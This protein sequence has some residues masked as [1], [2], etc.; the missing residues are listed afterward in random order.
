[1]MI[2][3]ILARYKEGYVERTATVF[4]GP[5]RREGFLSLG[6]AGDRA[7]VLEVATTVLEARKYPADGTVLNVEPRGAGDVPY[8]AF[9]VGDYVSAES[10]YGF[11]DPLRVVGFTVSEDLEGNP[12]YIPE[13]ATLQ[14]V[15]EE[16]LDRML[17]RMTSLGSLDGG[18]TAAAPLGQPDN[19]I[20]A[21]PLEP[22]QLP[23]FSQPGAVVVGESGTYEPEKRIRLTAWAITGDPASATG[24]TTARFLKNGVPYTLDPLSL[25]S[26]QDGN[27]SYLFGQDKAFNTTD[28]LSVE[29]TAAGGHENVV[30]HIQAAVAV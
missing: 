13:V 19:R 2:N 1:M 12:I 10:G 29:I 30:V 22:I 27:I 7:Q 14:Q 20:P 4:G 5:I 28:R 26:T 15:A 11:T 17:D 8:S 25:T 9:D 24:T 16:R 6:Q 23:P 18:T 21:G 3:R